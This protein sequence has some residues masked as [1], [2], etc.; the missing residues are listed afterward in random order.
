MLCF[1]ISKDFRPFRFQTKEKINHSFT[2]NYK[3]SE[4]SI[5]AKNTAMEIHQL[6]Q[7]KI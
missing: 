5:Q 1:F 7:E 4:P 6:N 3:Y 2:I